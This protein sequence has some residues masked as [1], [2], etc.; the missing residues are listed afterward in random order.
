M[1]K[2][3]TLWKLSKTYNIDLD[4]IIKI[5]KIT[6]VTNIEIGQLIFIPARPVQ[7]RSTQPNTFASDDFIWPLQGKTVALFGDSF[8]NMINKGINIAPLRNQDVVASRGGKVVFCSDN[9]LC[10]GKT[11]I[12]D[13]TDGF[14]TVYARNAE[15]LVKTGEYVKR[16]ALI[17]KAGQAGRDKNIFLH[18]EI[19]K[20]HIPRNPYF[21]LPR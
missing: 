18:F 15:L 14:S 19:R 12:I 21:Y 17:A 11:I 10:F 16:G 9:F 3:E 13:H 7:E 1:E 4:E 2:S 6:D 5:N 20:G 8:D